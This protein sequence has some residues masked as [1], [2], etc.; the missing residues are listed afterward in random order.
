MSAIPKWVV[1]GSVAIGVV[2][3]IC[4]GGIWLGVAAGR[5][6]QDPPGFG[7]T[8]A[9]PGPAPGPVTTLGNGPVSGEARP[10]VQAKMCPEPGPGCTTAPKALYAPQANFT[11]E[12]RKKKVQGLMT[13]WVTVTKDGVAE[14]ITLDKK[15]GYGLDEEAVKSVKTWKFQ[16]ATLDGKVVA[17]RVMIEVNFK[18]Y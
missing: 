3:V 12:A 11:K 4:V 16:P 15:L 7:G 18:L 13:M 1:K 5:D 14:N 17:A 9:P 10:K 8:G 2:V 6:L